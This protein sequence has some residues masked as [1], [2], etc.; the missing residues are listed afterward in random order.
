MANIYYACRRVPD[1]NS[2][3]G[4]ASTSAW[5]WTSSCTWSATPTTP[6]SSPPRSPAASCRT[7]CRLPGRPRCR[8]CRSCW[9]SEFTNLSEHL[10][11]DAIQEYPNL[12]NIPTL[13]WKSSVYNGGIYGMPIPRGAIGHYISSV[14]TCSRPPGCRRSP[15]PTRS[16]W[17]PPKLL[18]DPKKRRWAFS[19]VNQPRQSSATDERR[20]PNNWREEGGK[21]RQCTRPRSR[22]DRHRPDRDVEVRRDAP[23]LVQSGAALQALFNAG[24]RG[25]QR[26][27]RLSR[28]DSVHSGQRGRTRTSSSV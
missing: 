2:Y 9:R 26:S 4:R 25:H 17:R 18:T 14:R 19:L 23:R 3:G 12:A 13:T 27:R 20:V 7:C 8:T 15:S 5:A 22:A 21:L 10:S 11:G 1:K 6:R 16:S 24:T 28:L